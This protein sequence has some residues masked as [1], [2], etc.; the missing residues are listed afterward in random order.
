M[1]DGFK[2]VVS[3]CSGHCTSN[4]E[5]LQSSSTMKPMKDLGKLAHELRT[6]KNQDHR[7]GNT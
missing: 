2:V 6:T 1:T 4:S 3:K 7:P 5:T